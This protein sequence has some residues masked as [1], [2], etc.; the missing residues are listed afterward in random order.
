MEG[1]RDR[2]CEGQTS[3]Q[4]DRNRLYKNM[5]HLHFINLFSI[6]LFLVT[7]SLCRTMMAA[8]QISQTALP[9]TRSQAMARAS[10]R[11]TTP[12]TGCCE[13]PTSAAIQTLCASLGSAR[14]GQRP[15][16]LGHCTRWVVVGSG[17]VKGGAKHCYLCP[18]PN[19]NFEILIVKYV[20]ENQRGNFRKRLKIVQN[21]S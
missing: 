2:Q 18:F 16:R 4:A 10:R 13:Q 21:Q 17:G 1:G 9:P 3:E 15:S 6:R 5:M 19:N 14:R 11:P 8:V 20:T 12:Q 7:A